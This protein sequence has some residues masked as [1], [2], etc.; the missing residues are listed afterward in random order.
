MTPNDDDLLDL[1]R[2]FGLDLISRDDF[3][4]EMK[5]HGWSQDDIDGLCANGFEAKSATCV[6]ATYRPQRPMT[7]FQWGAY[8]A[9]HGIGLSELSKDFP[10]LFR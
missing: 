10:E 2:R 1:L 5:R 4:R 8:L 6:A 9:K 7:M 3:W